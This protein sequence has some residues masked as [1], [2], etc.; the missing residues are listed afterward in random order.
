[1]LIVAES[2]LA[3]A[4]FLRIMVQREERNAN[5][6]L[7]PS[8]WYRKNV[9]LELPV[10]DRKVYVLDSIPL[11]GESQARILLERFGT[12][13]K[14][15]KATKEELQRVPGIGAKKAEL[16]YGIFH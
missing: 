12:I 8:R 15:A 14:I 9:P 1:P 6:K 3:F 4:S 5:E 16:I 13:E 10:K 2:D 11:V 7:P